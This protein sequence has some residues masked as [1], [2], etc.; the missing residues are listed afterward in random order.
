MMTT[1]FLPISRTSVGTGPG[2]IN[3]KENPDG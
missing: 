3:G 1:N 2:W